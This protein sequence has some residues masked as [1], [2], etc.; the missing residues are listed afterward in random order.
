MNIHTITSTMTE[1]GHVS[2][3]EGWTQGRAL[4]GGLVA[5]LMYRALELKLGAIAPLRSATINFVAPAT[6]GDLQCEAEILRQGKSVTQG[7][8]RAVQIGQ[9]VAVLLASFGAARESV[10]AI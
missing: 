5:A 1:S 10:M 3:P 7:L 6:S 8:C 2:V 9:V 4:F